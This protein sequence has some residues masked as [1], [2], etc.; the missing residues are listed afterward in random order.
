M[1]SARPSA[2]H[3]EELVQMHDGITM[4]IRQVH[5]SNPSLLI[6][7]KPF[8]CFLNNK[9]TFLCPNVPQLLIYLY[10][11]FSVALYTSNP[12]P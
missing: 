2:G 3:Q 7:D 5:K 8:F 11:T 9:S 4:H 10:R 6:S 1:S 12:N